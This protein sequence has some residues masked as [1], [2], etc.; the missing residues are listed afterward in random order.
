[1][2]K[3]VYNASNS[4][5]T[6]DSTKSGTS[7]DVT[8]MNPQTLAVAL[9]LTSATAPVGITAT[10]QGSL[11]DASFFDIGSPV[12]LTA[13]GVEILVATSVPFAFYR[14]DYSRIAG[15]IISTE[16]FLIYGE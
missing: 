13:N 1:M 2:K 10:L 12:N 15:S 11:D 9:T 16:Q 3:P 6:I 7:L 8:G 4:P 14:V 5:I